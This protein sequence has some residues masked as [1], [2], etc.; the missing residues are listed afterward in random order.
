MDYTGNCSARSNWPISAIRPHTI[1]CPSIST[2]GRKTY[3]YHPP[4]PGNNASERGQLWYN[5]SH[6]AEGGGGEMRRPWGE[7][8]IAQ[9]CQLASGFSH[10]HEGGGGSSL[11]II[12]LMPALGIDTIWYTVAFGSFRKEAFFCSLLFS[13]MMNCL[14]RKVQENSVAGQPS[15]WLRHHVIDAEDLRWYQFWKV[16]TRAR[17]TQSK[18]GKLIFLNSVSKRMLNNA[19]I[20]LHCSVRNVKGL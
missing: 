17:Q 13:F 19:G 2:Y 10:M 5:E 11:G 8:A 7:R 3:L 16:G 6:G 1:V 9:R 4:R 20:I 14:P 15:H 18:W 12:H